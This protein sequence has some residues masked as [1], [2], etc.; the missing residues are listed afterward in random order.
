MLRGTISL[1]HFPRVRNAHVESEP[2]SNGF[3]DRC[4]ENHALGFM[5]GFDKIGLD[6]ARSCYLGQSRFARSLCRCLC[7]GA[8]AIRCAPRCRWPAK[9]PDKFGDG[10]IGEFA[11]SAV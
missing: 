4:S 10:A 9:A 8:I 5:C 2:R 11:G 3:I 7:V 6:E 1:G